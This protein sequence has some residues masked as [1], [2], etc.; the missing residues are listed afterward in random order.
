MSKQPTQNELFNECL[1]NMLREEN[2]QDKSRAIIKSGDLHDRA[3]GEN[4]MPTACFAMLRLAL[5]QGGKAELVSPLPNGPTSTIEIEF[6]TAD[7][8]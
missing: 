8:P 1:A 3:G 4:R 5:H 6:D 2:A 7:L